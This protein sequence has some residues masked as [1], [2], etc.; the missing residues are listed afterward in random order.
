LGEKK[1]TSRI[2]VAEP[3]GRNF[4]EDLGV[5]GKIIFKMDVKDD[6]KGVD[7]THL[8]QNVMQ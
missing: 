8:A 6:R 2:L 3:V 5:S 1:Y 4:A 7:W